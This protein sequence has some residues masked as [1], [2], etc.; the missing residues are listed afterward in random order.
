MLKKITSLNLQ[1]WLE[2]ENKS[3]VGDKNRRNQMREMGE[4]SVG[5]DSWNWE[6]LREGNLVQWTLVRIPIV[7][8][9]EV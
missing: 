6:A 1:I 5:R 3:Y 2:L 7:R 4:E 9:Y 8:E